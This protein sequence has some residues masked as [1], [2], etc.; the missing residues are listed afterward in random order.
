MGQVGGPGRPRPLGPGGGRPLPRRGRRRPPHAQRRVRP[1]PVGSHHPL[2]VA[3]RRRRRLPPDGRRPVGPRRHRRGAARVPGPDRAGHLLGL[4]HQP[5]ERPPRRPSTSG[6]SSSTWPWSWPSS[7]ACPCG[8]RRRPPSANGG[9][10]SGPWPPQRASSLPTIWC[11]WA[12]ARATQS[13]LDQL[14]TDLRPGVTE[15]VLRPAR[16][17]TELRAVA[18]DWPARVADHD[19]AM[20]A[21]SLPRPG[22]TVQRAAD[23]LPGPAGSAATKVTHP[24]VGGRSVT[25]HR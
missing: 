25:R 7:S 15:V 3:A 24:G 19:V 6:R 21:D 9:S 10:R 18:P 11:G 5:P 1:V 8:C 13:A 22:P 17:T 2:P 4:R 20:N 14:L 23:R 16:D 12:T